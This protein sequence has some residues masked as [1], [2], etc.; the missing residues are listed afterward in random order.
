MLPMAWWDHKILCPKCNELATLVEF[1][2]S[3][4]GELRLYYICY[5]CKETIAWRVYASGLQEI[6]RRNDLEKHCKNCGKGIVTP[7]LALP[8]PQKPPD[9][10]E[11]FMKGLGYDTPTP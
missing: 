4:D 7:P 1:N 6:A 10:F 11:E 9:D 3:A 5:T 8:A 2:F